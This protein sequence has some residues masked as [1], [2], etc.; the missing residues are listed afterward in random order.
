[1]IE[2]QPPFW[3]TIKNLKQ[4]FQKNSIFFKEKEIFE[5]KFAQKFMAAN[6]QSLYIN[7]INETEWCVN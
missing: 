2:N 5:Q 7:L 3:Y 6:D 1:M 4:I